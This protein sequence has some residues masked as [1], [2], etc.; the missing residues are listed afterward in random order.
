MEYRPLGR[1]GVRVSPLCL[2]TLN[3]GNP[4]DE[5][6]SIHII[7]AALDAGINFIDTANLYAGGESER[8]VG[9]ALADGRRQRVILGAKVYFP[10]SDD[11]NDR[12]SSRRHIMQAIEDSLRRLNTDWIDLY[13]LHRP[14]FDI[15]QDETL[16]ALDDLVRQGKVR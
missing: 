9:R 13:Q 15:P 14:V 10:Q 2:G 11:P 6:T 4:T 8:I 7:H 16:R 3:F 1:T 5:E 12:G